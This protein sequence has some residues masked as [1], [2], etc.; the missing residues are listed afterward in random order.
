MLAVLQG[1]LDQADDGVSAEQRIVIAVEFALLHARFDAPSQRVG[2]A[3]AQALAV[4]RPTDHAFVHEGGAHDTGLLLGIV[5]QTLEEDAKALFETR[6]FV[7][8]IARSLHQFFGRASRDRHERLAA[9]AE[10]EIEGAD[11]HVRVA[12]DVLGTRRLE[13]SLGEQ[14][15]GRIEQAL[16]RLGLAAL[17]PVGLE[18]GGGLGTHGRM[19]IC[20]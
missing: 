15:A 11:G 12:G 19:I 9:I 7:D 17:L 14:E 2:Q 13:A 16:A 6:A 10:V 3:I 5:E 18:G 20:Q 1:L 4:T 8:P